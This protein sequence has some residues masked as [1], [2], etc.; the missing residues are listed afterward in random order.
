MKF[1]LLIIYND[2][3]QS[4]GFPEWIKCF[5]TK[6]EAEQYLISN[7]TSGLYGQYWLKDPK[8]EISKPYNAY[9]IVDLKP[10]ILVEN[11]E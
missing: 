10:Y 8:E 6:E 5:E 9:K 4:R 7:S 2:F 1:F 3:L 11:N